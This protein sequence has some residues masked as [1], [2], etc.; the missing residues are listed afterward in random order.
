MS[1]QDISYTIKARIVISEFECS[2][3]YI[4]SAIGINPTKVWHRGDKVHPKATNEH[5]ENG[6]LLISPC[7]E[8]NSSVDEQ[9][10]ALSKI[11]LPIIDNFLKLPEEA[12]TELSCIVRAFKYMPSI[13]FSSDT[14]SFFSKLKASVDIDVY[15]LIGTEGESIKDR[16]A[17]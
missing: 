1:S 15:D 11:I 6:W 14:V 4:T 12:G 2:T 13:S 10:R 7:E 17:Q 3:D 5:K 9:V 16:R 8:A